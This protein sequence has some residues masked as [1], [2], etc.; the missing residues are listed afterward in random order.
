MI[1]SSSLPPPPPPRPCSRS[2][3]RPHFLISVSLSLVWVRAPPKLSP[4]N[5]SSSLTH[6]ILIIRPQQFL[7]ISIVYHLFSTFGLIYLISVSVIDVDK[8]C[9]STLI[10]WPCQ[11]RTPSANIVL[12]SQLRIYVCVITAFRSE[13]LCHKY[14]TFFW[15]AHV[16]LVSGHPILT[17]IGQYINT[18]SFT[19]TCVLS[20]T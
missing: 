19:H 8:Y 15:S 20:Q 1:P 6:H 14:F 3:P 4:F 9:I 13:L 16:T 17:N 11:E 7:T 5:H 10:M 12:G 18:C 2:R